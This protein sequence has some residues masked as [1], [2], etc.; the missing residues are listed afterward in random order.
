MRIEMS[1]S[2]RMSPLGS[3]FDSFLYAPIGEDG[4]GM[5]LSVLSALARL[6]VDPWEEAAQLAQLPEETAARKLASQIAALPN[7]S[8]VR[9]DPATIAPRLIALLPR[10][11][12][13]RIASRQKLSGVA[14]AMPHAPVMAYLMYYAVFIATILV[15]QWLFPSLPAASKIDAAP[16]SASSTISPQTPGLAR[17]NERP[18]STASD[19]AASSN[20][21]R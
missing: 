18:R 8:S 20:V 13:S 11:P 6:D 2:V 7:G 14:G 21:N 5:P 9:P 10:R 3:E 4:N 15:S 19:T 17:A 1:G 16:V 12:G